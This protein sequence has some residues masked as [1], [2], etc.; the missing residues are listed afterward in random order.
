MRFRVP[1]TKLRGL[2]LG[3]ALVLLSF[4]LG[5][6]VGSVGG[7]PSLQGVKEVLVDRTQPES[8]A[9]IDML[10]F[11]Q[12]WDTLEQKYLNDEDIKPQEMVW[13]AIAGMTKA[14]G[15]PYTVF[16]PP[17]EQEAS[18]EELNGTF[19]GV[20]I[21]LGFKDE[22][23][24]V[25]APL[26]GMPAEAAGVKAGDLILHIKD[27]N[28]G[29]DTDTLDMSLPK[30]VDTIRGPKG[31]AVILT[32]LHQGKVDP[33]EI[34]I[35]RDTIL[36]ASVELD[37]LEG[38][39]VA[40]LKLMRFGGNTDS[41]WDEVVAQIAARQ[42]QIRGVV[43]DLRNNPG[44]LLDGAVFIASEFL[45]NGVVV[46]QEN[47][48]GERVSASVNRNGKLTKIPM[49]VII[50]KGSASASEIVAGSLQDRK[51]ARL[52]GEKSFGKGTIQAPEEL[53]GG[54]GVHITIAKWLTPNGRWVNDTQ[55]LE[56]DILVEAPKNETEV[57][58]EDQPDPQLDK[59]MELLE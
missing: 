59:A 44:G 1:L 13:G 41:E 14:L 38:E 48:Q 6:R 31:T 33:V 22:V 27:E 39:S 54:A 12:V 49:V 40:H 4:W 47:N 32:L 34:A 23:L 17:K 24:A 52:V 20:G 15:D 7:K 43:L 46:L 45:D 26:S 9:Q 8:R 30:A 10:L 51:R 5:W 2:I 57:V 18:Q 11:W 56:P 35:V 37:W 42:N 55:G 50:N 25:I 58:T 16:L 19:E 29:V 36:I 21:Q 53:E 3:V 28:R